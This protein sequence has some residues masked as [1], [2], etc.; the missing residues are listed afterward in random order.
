MTDL[1]RRIRTVEAR[2]SPDPDLFSLCIPKLYLLYYVYE[3]KYG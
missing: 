1:L 3:H 2:N